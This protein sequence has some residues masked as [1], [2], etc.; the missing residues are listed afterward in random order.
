[1]PAKRANLL[2]AELGWIEK[3]V[4]GW[5][6]TEAGKKMGGVMR[7][8]RQTGI[9]YVVWPASI[10]TNKV[11]V[12]T[13]KESAGGGVV[14]EGKSGG[15]GAAKSGV[16]TVAETSIQSFRERFPAELRATDGHM[17][18]SRAELLIDN[19]LYMQQIVHAV[20]R[21]LPVEEDALCDF[22]LPKGKVYIEFWGMERDPKYAARMREKKAI[23]V[24]YEMNL[25]EL[26]DAEIE[27]LDDVLP[28]LLLK[29]GIDCT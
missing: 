19:W 26:G 14:A 20:E 25:V 4:K 16:A 29:Y 28:R 12:G 23:Y 10:L 27:S 3:H 21:K 5:H 22:Y 11:L 8:A 1:M 18:R 2:L 17:V 15:S 9:P 13:M 24:K 7:E 6:L